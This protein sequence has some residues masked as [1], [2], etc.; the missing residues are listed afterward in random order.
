MSLTSLTRA[1]GIPSKARVS[2]L[3]KTN[4]GGMSQPAGLAKKFLE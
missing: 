1:V 2:M 4:T 3:S